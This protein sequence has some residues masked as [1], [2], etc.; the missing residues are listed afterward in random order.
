MLT[1]Y[2]QSHYDQ[3][4]H[5][6]YEKDAWYWYSTVLYCMYSGVCTVYTVYTYRTAQ[7]VWT[8]RGPRAKSLGKSFDP[9]VAFSQ[10]CEI[11]PLYFSKCS[12]NLPCVIPGRTATI[13]KSDGNGRMAEWWIGKKRGV[14]FN[15]ESIRRLCFCPWKH[16]INLK[17]ECV[18][19]CCVLLRRKFPEDLFRTTTKLIFALLLPEK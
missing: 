19:R 3:D 10:S 1:I 12:R 14:G 6:R 9:Q 4:M 8:M 13:R 15:C 17:I 5:K 2:A 18:N 11:S 7:E 16:E